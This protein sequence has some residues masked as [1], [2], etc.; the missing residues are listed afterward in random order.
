MGNTLCR[1]QQERVTAGIYEMVGD[2]EDGVS[3]LRT[4]MPLYNFERH[5]D[6]GRQRSSLVPRGGSVPDMARH[7]CN[8]S[9]VPPG[10]QR[11]Q[12]TFQ[13]G[14]ALVMTEREGLEANLQRNLE[15]WSWCGL[16]SR[17]WWSRRY[18]IGETVLAVLAV[19]S[20][21]YSLLRLGVVKSGVEWL[22]AARRPIAAYAVV[23]LSHCIFFFQWGRTSYHRGNVTEENEALGP[24]R[25]GLP[26]IGTFSYLTSPTLPWSTL[27]LPVYAAIRISGSYP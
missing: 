8:P 20:T 1:C 25:Q 17:M 27:S 14:E 23:S 22:V 12:T 9:R 13:T 7:D 16:G 15:A 21:S 5:G 10:Q 24:L 19:R 18:G 11:R 4:D 26:Q 3:M 2:V 6:T